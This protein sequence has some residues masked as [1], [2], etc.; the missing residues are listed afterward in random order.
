M[1]RN[2]PLKGILRHCVLVF[3]LLFSTINLGSSG[4]QDRTKVERNRGRVLYE[5]A[6]VRDNLKKDPKDDKARLELAKGLY[7]AGSF[8]ESEQVLEPLLKAPKPSEEAMFLMAELDYLLGDYGNAEARLARILAANPKDEDIRTKAGTKLAFAYYQTN[9]YA[10]AQGLYKGLE[11]RINLPHWDLMKAFGQ[12]RPYQQTWPAGLE[13][14]EIPFLIGDPLPVLPVEVQ[15][16]QVIVFI[17]TGADMFVLDPEAA[18]ALGIKPLV[19]M[20]GT[21]AGGLKAEVGLGKAE[22]I[23]I[24]EVTLSSVPVSLLPTMRFS[25]GLTGGKYS[26]GGIIGTGFLRQF[27]PTIDY[28]G[29]KLVLRPATDAG[30]AGF[31]A[32]LRRMMVVEVPFVLAS[33]HFM[34]ARGSLNERENLSFFVDSGLASDAAFAATNQTLEY[35]NIALP[36]TKVEKGNIGGGGGAGFATGRFSVKELGL[37]PLLQK[38]LQGA[39]GVLPAQT[40]W[41]QGFILDGLISHQFL[42]KYSWT[43]DSAGMKMVFVTK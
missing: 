37:G 17:D 15:G 21:F 35:A 2:A 28:P 26:I 16:R 32:E 4:L 19:S 40:Y 38:N 22:S 34:I 42:R 24:G 5:I 14:T 18:A 10:R 11:D 6:V 12:E 29:G 30:R 7:Q 8:D 39:F 36:E 27:L 43:I 20:T 3:C 41:G 33:T 1:T 31:R 25:E 13:K 23:K 9:Q